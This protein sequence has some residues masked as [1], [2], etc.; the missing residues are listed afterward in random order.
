MFRTFAEGQDQ[1]TGLIDVGRT[2]SDRQ[3]IG[4]TDNL[5][6]RVEFRQTS[7]TVP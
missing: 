4:F 5:V 3:G 1:L 6:T 7:F 2:L